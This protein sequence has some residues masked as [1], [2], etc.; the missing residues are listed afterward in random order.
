MGVIILMGSAIGWH[1]VFISLFFALSVFSDT[2]AL[3]CESCVTSDNVALPN[4]KLLLTKEE[5]FSSCIKGQLGLCNE[6]SN[7]SII[8][9]YGEITGYFVPIKNLFYDLTDNSN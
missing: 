3:D 1:L 9:S 7:H 4:L 6:D 8:C 2:I 5:H